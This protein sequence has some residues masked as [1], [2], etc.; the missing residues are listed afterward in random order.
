MTLAARHPFVIGCVGGRAVFREALSG[1]LSGGLED[2]GAVALMQ[3]RFAQMV[4]AFDAGKLEAS[5]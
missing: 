4:A 3:G 1:W 5:R 2:H